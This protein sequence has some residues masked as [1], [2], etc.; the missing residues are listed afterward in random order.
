MALPE[1]IIARPEELARCCEYLASCP[2]IGFD[3][4]FVGE[5]TYHPHLCLVQVATEERLILI[6]PLTAGP[7]DAFW[8]LIV[9]PARQV[10]VHAGREEVRL[11]SLW[12][13]QVPGNL[14]DLQ[15]AAG[16]I[17]LT[18]PLGHGG[19]I[20]QVLGIQIAKGETLT[21]WR[22]R[23]LTAAQ[24]RYAFDDVRFL[25]PLG[26]RL[27]NRLAALDRLQWAGEEFARLAVHAAPDEAGLMGSSEKWRKLRGLGSLDRRR[28]AMV[29]ELYAWRE[30][31]AARTNRPARTIC[32][33]DLLI[34]IARRNP[35]RARDLQVVRGLPRRD[36][37]AVMEV[38]ER[39]RKLPMAQCPPAAEREQDPPQVGLISSV[40]QAVLGDL[41]ARL[42]LAPNLVAT[43]QDIKLLVRARLQA[44]GGDTPLPTESL[45]T[46]GW[47]GQHVLPEL[48]AVLE[49]RRSV[50]IADVRQA[51]PFAYS[52]T[53]PAPETEG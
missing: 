35:Q 9:D 24:V 48:L 44:A 10:I 16:L 15:I 53:T 47:R 23:P 28:L 17:G 43:S 37:D 33:D 50:R 18:Y 51:A 5:D 22:T 25:L 11:C 21:E 7:L 30:E 20:N 19:L 8:R 2:R 6:D 36:L 27:S 45:L 40:L 41:C 34:E 52:P 14:F 29:R 13:G 49:G 26:T 31:T 42:H 32:R 3:T 4:E 12:T 46:Q 38:I 39:A 1:Q